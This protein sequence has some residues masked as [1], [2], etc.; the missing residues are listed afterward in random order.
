[1]VQTAALTN[2]RFP[3]EATVRPS[4]TMKTVDR[5]ARGTPRAAADSGSVLAKASGRH[6]TT[7]PASTTAEVTRSQDSCGV[8]TATICPVNKPNLF[9]DRPL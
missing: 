3:L 4:N 1:M 8:S 5:A 6:T 7:S 9:A 2:S